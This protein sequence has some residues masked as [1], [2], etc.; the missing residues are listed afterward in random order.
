MTAEAAQ[1][2]RQTLHRR[3][4]HTSVLV[5]ASPALGFY[6]AVHVAGLCAVAA[7]AS[8]VGKSP[9]ALLGARWDAV[10][11][12]RI[13]TQ[14][15]GT[16]LPSRHLDRIFND[17][18]FFPLLPSLERLAS[19]VS[20]LSAQTAGILLSTVAG[21]VAACGIYAVAEQLYGRGA[22]LLT[23]A[24]W[25]MLPNAVVQTMGYTEA[26]MTALSAWSLHAL[27]RRR[28]V[29]AGSLACLAGLARPNGMAVAVAV[30]GCALVQLRRPGERGKW[31]VWAA[32]VLSFAGWAGYVL[33][34]GARTGHL[35]GYL[36][37]QARWGSSFDFG[38]YTAGYVAGLFVR[39]AYLS[40]FVSAL[41]LCAALMLLVLLPG[42]R[43]PAPLIIYTV[44]LVVMALGVA[45]Y[46]TSKPRLLMPAF[47]LLFPAAL[48]ARRAGRKALPALAVGAAFCVVYGV[49]LVLIAPTA[50]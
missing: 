28:W 16:I 8:A 3:A 45:H 18:A 13:A 37:V 23:A 31:Q 6:T 36:R 15:Y 46:F 33:W 12:T 29:T 39:E 30:A 9:V 34:V 50:P 7:A 11:Y 21:A 1:A 5:R 19:E 2:V 40:Q 17:L 20:P 14:G 22:G 35:L 49:Y 32:P 4:W 43:P 26:L 24:L 38:R 48:A 44:I 47:P 41:I 10:W 25:A 27:L 42:R